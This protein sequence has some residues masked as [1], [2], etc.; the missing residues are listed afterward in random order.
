MIDAEIEQRLGPVVVQDEERRELAPR[1]ERDSRLHP[2]IE[3]PHGLDRG[4]TAE[5]V[6]A[7]ARATVAA[8]RELERD[9]LFVRESVGGGRR[10]RVL[11]A[12]CVHDV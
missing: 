3:S 4:V 11:E 7:V 9:A 8:L 6:V 10:G 5:P 2:I 1:G 12:H